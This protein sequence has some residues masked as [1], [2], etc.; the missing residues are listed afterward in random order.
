[1][2]TILLS[3]KK[4]KGSTIVMSFLSGVGRENGDFFENLMRKY[5]KRPEIGRFCVKK[6]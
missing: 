2:A 1:M 3:T 5:K 6:V 4:I